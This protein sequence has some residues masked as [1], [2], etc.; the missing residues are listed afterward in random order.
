MA[1]FTVL[2]FSDSSSSVS[3]AMALSL[4]A[5]IVVLYGVY[6]PSFGNDTWHDVTQASQIIE[7]GGLRDLTIFHEA[8]PFP[9]VS[10][11][12][13]VYSIVS[14]LSTPWSSSVI[15]LAHRLLLAV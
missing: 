7:R 14:G 12:Y 11:L 5:I 2:A 4:T 3:L 15:G 9:V 6:S 1:V 8:Y 13:A 10:I